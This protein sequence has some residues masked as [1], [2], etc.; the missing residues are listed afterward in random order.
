[1]RR[2]SQTE[3]ASR[4][5]AR[6][7]SVPGD[8]V[9]ASRAYGRAVI[10]HALLRASGPEALAG[11]DRPIAA[12]FA[13]GSF[14]F[15]VG[16]FPGVVQLIGA[17]P[18]AALFFVG[19]IFFTFAA[20]LELR[21]AT[22]RRGARF[23]ADLTWW[24]AAIQF[25]GTL[26]FNVSTFDATRADFSVQQENKLIWAPDAIGS[27]CFLVS[28]ALAYLI[29]RRGGRHDRAWRMAAVNLAG[30][31]FF[32]ISAIASYVVPATG[33]ILDLAAANWNT[34]LGAACFLAG[35]VM[36][37]PASQSTRPQEVRT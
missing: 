35:A 26:W 9:R 10:G 27:A 37:W 33:S 5:P 29:A 34:S 30:C 28:G 19:S 3:R 25:V 7:S 20:G 12:G 18:D 2:S 6:V 22:L 31:V 17:G 8:A 13:V 11:W 14:F 36:L 4:H 32:G 23:G 15:L 24:S 21:Q 1:M 16:P